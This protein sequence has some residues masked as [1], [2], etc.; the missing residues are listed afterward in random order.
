[1]RLLN[2]GILAD[3]DAQIA[4]LSGGQG[5]FPAT[6]SND[7][8]E[9]SIPMNG[10]PVLAQSRLSDAAQGIGTLM[11]VTWVRSAMLVRAN[12]LS[13]GISGVRVKLLTNLIKL[14]ELNLIPEV[15]LRGSISASGDLIP[16]SYVANL[17]QGSPGIRVSVQSNGTKKVVGADVALQEAGISPLQF[18]PKEALAL[19]NGT[20]FSA[21]AAALILHDAHVSTALAQI[22]TAMAVEALHGTRESFDP[23]FAQ[24]RPHPGQE[25]IAY[26]IS[27][28]LRES[29]FVREEIGNADSNLP[30]D[31]YSLRTVP[32]WLGPEIEKLVLAHDQVV[33][34][35]NSITDNPLMAPDG[36]V[37]QGGNFQAST[38]TSAMDTTRSSLQMSGRMLFQQLT[39]MMN[40]PTN[41]GLPPSLTADEPSCDFLMKGMDVAAASYTSELAFLSHSVTSFVMNAEQ[42]NQS[43]N[44]LA[45]ISAR[46]TQT[47]LDV[48]THLVATM[49]V[50]VCQALDLRAI[51]RDFLNSFA[52]NFG[53][54]TEKWTS[55]WLEGGLEAREDARARLWIAFSSKFNGSASLDSSERFQ[56]IMTSL[57]EPARGLV[58][59]RH[60]EGLAQ[61]YQELDQWKSQMAAS[62]QSLYAT[63]LDQHSASHT[64]PYLGIASKAMYS[65]VREAQQVP[66]LRRQPLASLS[67]ESVFMGGKRGDTLGTYISRIY[68]ALK[69]GSLLPVVIECLEEAHSRRK[70]REV[71]EAK[72]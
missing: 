19:V 63:T 4:E 29:R 37:M 23:Y 41:N 66:F 56:S 22:L 28:F 7:S 25:E 26:N 11:P 48:F 39:E 47:A 61:L 59:T 8:N 2:C 9:R 67:R 49:L 21:G 30:Q 10:L 71:R 50:A 70:A 12:S 58:S 64:L 65:Y 40:P 5:S 60:Y 6:G 16:L 69:R 32:Q 46:Y 55:K 20:A 18:A 53:Y 33:T 38:I 68:V 27:S 57:C 24:V 62:A 34:E 1:M 35:C 17:L 13:H 72:L 45:L 3:S 44:S 43:L 14:L 52:G 54:E 31:R 51:Q 15:P 42:G 36:R